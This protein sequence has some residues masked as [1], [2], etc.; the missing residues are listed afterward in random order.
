MNAT[1]MKRL[2]RVIQS[3]TSADVDTLCRR[4]I[5]EEKKQGHGRVA[6]ELEQI[7]TAKQSPKS[8]QH[9]ARSIGCPPA[10]GNPRR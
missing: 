8:A 9:R 7:L 4:V 6:K 3:G 1:L 2:F 5:D 10:G